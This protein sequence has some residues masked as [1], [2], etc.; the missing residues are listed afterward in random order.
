MR[1]LVAFGVAVM[2]AASAHAAEPPALARARTLYNAG[3]FDNAVTE[4]AAARR[5]PGAADAAA[6]IEAR[7]HLE[8]Y[9]RSA[10]PMD[11]STARAALVAVN[12]QALA[13][14]DHLDLIVGLGQSLFFGELYGA[15]AQLFDTAL[16]RAAVLPVKDRLA[17]LDW[18][19]SAL[20][21]DAQSVPF[22]ARAKVFGRIVDRMTRELTMDPG[23]GPANYWLAAALRGAGDLDEAWDAAI[24]G[25]VRVALNPST[26]AAARTDLNR[27]V[28]ER[29]VADR[30]HR[31]PAS[32]QVDTEAAF[33]SVWDRVKQEWP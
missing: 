6:V 5:Q 1:V 28:T 16:E 14:R 31:R 4:A 21:R 2:M 24:A 26:A 11:L 30:A 23:S 22:E 18:W 29:L 19:A 7:A 20:D 8:R 33:T 10:D 3:D 9:R 15:A 13:P 27:L 25:W 32:E 17:L 12:P